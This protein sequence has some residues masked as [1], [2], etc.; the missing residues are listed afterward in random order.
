MD[1]ETLKNPKNLSH[2]HEW[3]TGKTNYH[4]QLYIP[5][6]KADLFDVVIGKDDANHTIKINYVKRLWTY[7]AVGSQD[8]MTIDHFEKAVSPETALACIKNMLE[9]SKL[10]LN[11]SLPPIGNPPK[12]K[13][14]PIDEIHIHPP[15]KPSARKRSFS[16]GSSLQN[17]YEEIDYQAKYWKLNEEFQK[18]TKEWHKVKKKNEEL[19]AQNEFQ[20]RLIQTKDNTI[21]TLKDLLKQKDKELVNLV[22]DD[23]TKTLIKQVEEERRVNK[24][25]ADSVI[26]LNDKILA[27]SGLNVSEKSGGTKKLS[28]AQHKLVSQMKDNFNQVIPDEALIVPPQNMD[29]SSGSKSQ[30]QRVVLEQLPSNMGSVV[31]RD[32]SQPNVQSKTKKDEKNIK[33]DKVDIFHK[34]EKCGKNQRDG[35]E[36]LKHIHWCQ[37]NV[38]ASPKPYVCPEINC[39]YRSSSKGGLRTHM[40]THKQTKKPCQYCGKLIGRKNVRAHEKGSCPMNREKD[41]EEE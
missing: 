11:A 29:T 41:G 9:G 15:P 25:L 38:Q 5:S 13:K 30:P 36:Y 18:W 17:A 32:Q 6:V 4:G 8:K 35:V 24:S 27:R 33:K 31:S 39:D 16:V 21:N 19:I 3:T 23:T 40:D 37:E 2:D 34:C 22:K 12:T 7:F 14:R 10:E 1:K 26:S 20:A 28:L